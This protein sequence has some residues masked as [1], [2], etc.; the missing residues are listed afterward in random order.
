[1]DTRSQGYWTFGLNGGLSYQQS[2]IN[3]RL[4]GYGVG[5]TLAK[6]LYYQPGAPFAFD[7]RGRALYSQS[8]GLDA[9]RSYGI[10]R[11]DAINGINNGFVDY[12]K[13]GGGPGFVFQNHKTHMG[14]LG[15]EAVLTFNE[16]REKTNVILSVFGGV[17]ID[18]Y[19]T[20]LDQL[21]GT[22]LYT[23]AY[24]S[25]DTMRS[26][27]S[28]RQNLKNNI[29]DG[30][31]ETNAAE[32]GDFGRIGIM[33]SLGLELGYQL[34]PKFSIGLGHKVTFSGT[35]LLDGQKW[36]NDNL[37]TN[38]NDIHH[39]TNLHLR[40][41]VQP[42]EDRL[43]PPVI[44]IIEP[45]TNPHT[46][47]DP[48]GFVRAKISNINSAMD[49]DFLVNGQA[50]RFDYDRGYLNSSFLLEPGR[51]EVLITAT[52]TAGQ[53]QKKVLI[54]YQEAVIDDP[55]INDPTTPI[56]PPFVDITRPFNNSET[57]SDDRY[58]LEAEV[59][60]VNRKRDINLRVNGRSIRDFRYSTSR[61]TLTADIRLK[62]GENRIDIE[63]RNQDGVAE[64]QAV[65]YLEEPYYEAPTVRITKP[66]DN[67]HYTE[68]SKEVLEAK[69]RNVNNAADI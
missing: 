16:L 55:I 4:N 1:Q 9:E 51:N 31:Y 8:Y 23:D 49:V 45:F 63:V 67:P 40:W 34:T 15:L 6:N 33:P 69:I 19:K 46:T 35:D 27:S 36:N 68:K 26:F 11:N 14:E 58:R 61:G 5:L 44:K 37:A 10:L 18:W 25:I 3:A 12:T 24:T 28:I 41:I 39:Y 56:E 52:N 32:H 48:N 17:G 38:N 13:N 43:S 53:D 22:T 47:R 21:D 65:I 64:D 60:Y 59:R 54:L 42:E 50:R 20:N 57:V 30:N 66:Y 29:L 7:L 2:D 62:T